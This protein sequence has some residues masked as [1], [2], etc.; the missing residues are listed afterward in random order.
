MAVSLSP[1]VSPDRA[2]E[3]RPRHE[4]LEEVEVGAKSPWRAVAA[5]SVE[6]RLFLDP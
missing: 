2:I 5:G 6:D 4:A 3:R 1:R